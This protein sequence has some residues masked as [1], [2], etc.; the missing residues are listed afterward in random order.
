[1]GIYQFDGTNTLPSIYL[2]S[3]EM[4]FEIKGT[5]FPEDSIGFYKPVFDWLKEFEKS[6]AS[7]LKVRFRFDYCNTSSSKIVQNFFEIFERLSKKGTLITVDWFYDP[8]D[9]DI[10]EA[11]ISY[12]DRVTYQVNL[13]PFE[14]K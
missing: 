10:Y 1:M 14:K 12:A 11:G 4:V 13:V 7:D 5:S 2:N 6:Q 8:D 3:E 9:E